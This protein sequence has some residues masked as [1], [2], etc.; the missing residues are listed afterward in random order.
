MLFVIILILFDSKKSLF[1]AD[2]I[3]VSQPLD[4]AKSK[5]FTIALDD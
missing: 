2:I 1:L 4:E 5:A 3:Q